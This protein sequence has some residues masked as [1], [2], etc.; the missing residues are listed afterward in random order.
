MPPRAGRLSPRRRALVLDDCHA[1]DD[2]GALC[3]APGLAQ[4]ARLTQTTQT[5]QRSEAN[6]G[7]RCAGC[8]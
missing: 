3:A 1:P 4:P 7:P 5:R 2:T 6:P 8:C